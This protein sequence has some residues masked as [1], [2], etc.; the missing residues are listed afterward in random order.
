MNQTNP[1]PKMRPSIA[2]L[3]AIVA[4]AIIA[5]SGVYVVHNI[6][7]KL[8]RA[9]A[10]SAKRIELQK[11][12]NALQKGE[13]QYEG[14]GP[15]TDTWQIIATDVFTFIVI[16]FIA[17]SALLIVISSFIAFSNRKPLFFLRLFYHAHLV[18]LLANFIPF[19]AT[20]FIIDQ[21]LDRFC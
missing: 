9:H 1:S 17:I 2:L 8:A 19:I 12:V 14:L 6:T 7:A 18:M 20:W 21:S 13:L 4:T 11:Q 16:F 15:C 3:L 5:G 10:V